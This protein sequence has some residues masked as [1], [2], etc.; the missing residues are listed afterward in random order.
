[1]EPFMSKLIS[2]WQSAFIKGRNIM[3]GVLSVHELIHE[4]KRKNRQGIMVK[5]DFEKAYDKVDWEYLFH[6]ISQKCF[7]ALWCKMFDLVIRNETLCVKINDRRGKDFGSLT[8]P[9]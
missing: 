2:G 4:A 9:F 5:L 6:C 7:S 8:L 3:D 1:V